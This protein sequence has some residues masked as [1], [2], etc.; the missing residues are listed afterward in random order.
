MKTTMVFFVSDVL[1]T[2][3]WRLR[4]EAAK[5]ADLSSF[6]KLLDQPEVFKALLKDWFVYAMAGKDYSCIVYEA[7]D[8]PFSRKGG[9]RSEYCKEQ[10]RK[11]AN[12]PA[13]EALTDEVLKT[14][15]RKE[16]VAYQCGL[17]ARCAKIIRE[18]L[19]D[20]YPEFRFAIYSGYEIDHGPNKDR[21]RERYAVDWKKM[22]D[23]GLDYATA[24]YFGSAD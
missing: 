20:A 5:G 22:A 11:A 8:G 9:D 14:K 18:V 3:Q 24:G 1:T 2:Y 13:E 17:T 23:S 15:Y 19:D 12:I 6:N 10:F 16:W 4:P 21:T 7:E